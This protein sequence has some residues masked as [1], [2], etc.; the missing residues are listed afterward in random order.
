MAAHPIVVQSRRAVIGG[1][2]AG[3]S[4]SQVAP[5]T[6]RSRKTVRIWQQRHAEHGDDWLTGQWEPKPEHPVIPNQTPLEVELAIADWAL[7]HPLAGPRTI[8]AGVQNR[9]GVRVGYSAVYNCLRRR[10]LENRAKRREELRRR[11]GPQPVDEVERDRA[12][13]R[14]RHLHAPEPGHIAC[15]DTAVVGRLKEAALVH[16][17]VA[18][19]GHSSYGSVVL[20]PERN[21]DMAAAALERLHSELAG[22][23]IDHLARTLTD[24][25]TEYKGRPSH[26]LPALCARLGSEHRHTKV[27]HAWTKGV[28]A[29]CTFSLRL[30]A[31]MAQGRDRGRPVPVGVGTVGGRPVHSFPVSW[32]GS[33]S[34]SA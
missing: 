18:I 5:E 30:S 15:C 34:A 29:Y 24:N 20:A 19:D 14:Q 23:G 8:L 13:S 25:G 16:M 10:G 9:L 2:A 12:L 32:S 27:R 33:H 6:G 11:A 7:E 31:G 28:A 3:K 21:A 4:K 26:A 22:L 1:L 17:A